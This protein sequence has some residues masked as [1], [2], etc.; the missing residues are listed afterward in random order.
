MDKR[1]GFLKIIVKDVGPCKV[2]AVFYE[3]GMGGSSGCTS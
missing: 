2:G 1:L 3:T